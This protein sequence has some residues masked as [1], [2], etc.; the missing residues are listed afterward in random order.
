MGGSMNW[1]SFFVQSGKEEEIKLFMDRFYALQ[2]LSCLVPKRMIPERKQ[3]KTRHCTKVLFP[4]YIFI[5]TGQIH[6]LYYNIK[7]TPY[8]LYMVNGGIHK[9]DQAAN[10]FTPIPKEQM[11]WLIQLCGVNGTMGYSDIIIGGNQIKVTSGP[12]LG[13]EAMIRK[14]DKR[15]SRAKIEVQLLNEVKLID[16]GINVLLA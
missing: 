11:D 10:F 14:I 2:H 4:G 9:H 12:L 5:Q 3:G 7:K 16:V 1:Y 15:K 6:D 8:I 13:K